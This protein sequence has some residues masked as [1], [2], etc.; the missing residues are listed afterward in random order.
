MRGLLQDIHFNQGG[1]VIL[2]ITIYKS[3]NIFLFFFSF[4]ISEKIE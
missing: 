2:H 4:V 3:N 1:L